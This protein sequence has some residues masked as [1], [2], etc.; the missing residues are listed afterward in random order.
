MTSLYVARVL[1]SRS[2]GLNGFRGKQSEGEIRH[3]QNCNIVSTSLSSPSPLNL[4]TIPP[5]L[6]VT[7]R[8]D[9][10]EHHSEQLSTSR[11]PG[12]KHMIFHSGPHCILRLSPSH[13]VTQV[14]NSASLLNV[15]HT[16]TCASFTFV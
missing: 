8:W 7:D 5:T 13:T 10:S 14:H 11:H 6:E 3:T 2:G 4:S 1:Y 12:K 16:P 15:T 9:Q